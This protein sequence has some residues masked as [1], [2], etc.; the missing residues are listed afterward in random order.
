MM[1]DIAGCCQELFKK[2]TGCNLQDATYA[3]VIFM[4]FCELF[5]NS[6]FVEYLRVAVFENVTQF[7]AFT[8]FSKSAI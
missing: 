2:A 8:A 3:T 1:V 4:K 6:F 5:E 7:S